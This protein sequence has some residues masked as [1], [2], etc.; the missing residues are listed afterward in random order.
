MGWR[1][2]A[3][4]DDLLVEALVGVACVDACAVLAVVGGIDARLS[5]L[6]LVEV[7]PSLTAAKDDVTD[8]GEV[9]VLGSGVGEV[10]V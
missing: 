3:G 2:G 1:G 8:C 6:A 9:V 5:W 10:V 4:V 7:E